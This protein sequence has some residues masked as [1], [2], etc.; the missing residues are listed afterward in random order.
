[1]SALS[2]FSQY[3]EVYIVSDTNITCTEEPLGEA[4]HLDAFKNQNEA[5]EYA[6]SIIK[7]Y[8]GLGLK[9]S[10]QKAYVNCNI[11]ITNSKDEEMSSLIIK[12]RRYYKKYKVV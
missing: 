2:K 8:H 1:M 12:R 5:I 4:F 11:K 9:T 3:E 6:N 7:N 10:E